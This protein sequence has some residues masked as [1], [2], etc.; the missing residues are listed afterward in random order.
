MTKKYYNT[1]VREGSC[2]LQWFT[3]KKDAK[4]WI[5]SVGY[6]IEDEYKDARCNNVITVYEAW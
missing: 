4:A 6:E 2:I 5:K 3:S 1:V